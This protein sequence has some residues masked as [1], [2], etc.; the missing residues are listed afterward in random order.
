VYFLQPG[1]GCAAELLY[2]VCGQ[3]AAAKVQDVLAFG[4]GA[5]D[6]GQQFGVREC[7]RAVFN[8]TLTGA[9]LGLD[10]LDANVV[11]RHVDFFRN[12]W[13]YKGCDFSQ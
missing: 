9:V 3:Y 4:A 12:L 10:V 8:K 13:V 1:G 7:G 11:F 2:V 6:D 5:Q